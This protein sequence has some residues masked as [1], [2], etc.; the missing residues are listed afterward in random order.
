MTRSRYLSIPPLLPATFSPEADMLEL[1]TGQGCLVNIPSPQNHPSDSTTI[2][3]TTTTTNNNNNNQSN[4]QSSRLVCVHIIRVRSREVAATRDGRTDHK[5]EGNGGGGGGERGYESSQ[6]PWN[7][8][9][10]EEQGGTTGM[11]HAH[12]SGKNESYRLIRGVAQRMTHCFFFLGLL[13]FAGV[14]TVYEDAQKAPKATG[15]A[16]LVGLGSIQVGRADAPREPH[17][18][19]LNDR[20][21]HLL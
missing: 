2:T 19:D 21:K 14:S 17:H 20:I 18:T 4:L 8:K 12:P 11:P 3:T 7:T 16:I 13:C 5:R 6:F 15:S 10:A 9:G 1:P